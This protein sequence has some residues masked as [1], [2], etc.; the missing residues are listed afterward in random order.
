MRVSYPP[1]DERVA[2]LLPAVHTFDKAHIVALVNGGYIEMGVAAE[3]LRRLG[4]MEGDI[5][6]TRLRHGGHIHSG[7]EYLTARL[8]EHD[9]GHLHTGRSS[10]DLYAVATRVTQRRRYI[11]LAAAQLA[12]IDTCV[13]LAERELSTVMPSYSHLQ[14]AQSTTFAHYM[15]GWVFEATRGLARVLE[16]AERND[17]SPAGAAVGTGSPFA[18]DPEFTAELL[19]FSRAYVNSREAIWSVDLVIEGLW[20][21][22]SVAGTWARLADDLQILATSEFAMVDVG[23][24]FSIN[25]SILPQKKNPV[26]L[27]HVRGVLGTALGHL[28]AGV[29][30]CRAP[31]DTLVMDREL[32]I[33]GLWHAFDDVV[34]GLNL[35]S[36]VLAS[37]SVNRVRMRE[38]AATSW[39]YASDLAS[40]MVL[41]E[42][43]SWREAQHVVSTLVRRAVEASKPADQVSVSDLQDAASEYLGRPLTGVTQSDLADAQDPERSVRR[44]VVAG[45]PAPE[46]VTR[47]IQIARAALVPSRATI[48]RGRERVTMGDS[49]LAV[50]VA[51]II[52]ASLR[53]EDAAP[54]PAGGVG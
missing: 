14:H 24:A 29:T 12:L 22:V 37:I 3:M 46:D 36:A 19:G 31:S 7:E 27:Q 15:M 48:D 34:G 23:E 42:N 35:M 38:V 49:R 20:S 39:A 30:I 6:G 44:R 18:L 11:E 52:D 47:Q 43:L 5:T 50:A 2:P 16:A 33:E 53:T 9:A 21:C 13:G 25:S 1:P 28:T 32:A 10:G 8:G 40:M 26:A 4:E 41:V 45:G 17:A 51:Q 54:D